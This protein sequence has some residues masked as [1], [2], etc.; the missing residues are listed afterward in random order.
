MFGEHEW[1]VRPLNR[2]CIIWPAS[3]PSKKK[4]SLDHSAFNPS[5]PGTVFFSLMSSF[6]IRTKQ[7][8][9]TKTRELIKDKT[10]QSKINANIGFQIHSIIILICW[11]FDGLGSGC[12]FYPL[13][14]GIKR[15]VSM[16]GRFLEKRTRLWQMKKCL[17]RDNSEG[18]PD[19]EPNWRLTIDIGP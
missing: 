16:F 4:Q 15:K 14:S 2:A 7:K 10:R 13:L 1:G 3:K 6:S 19:G 11:S 5:S 17:L 18:L 8:R 9:C 12:L